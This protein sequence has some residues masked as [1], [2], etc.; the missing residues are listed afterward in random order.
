MVDHVTSATALVLP[1]AQIVA[2]LAERG[3]DTLVDGAHAP[4]MLDVD[5]DAT[6]A[7]YYTGT[8]HKWLFAP[9][10]SGFLHVRADLRDRVRPLAISHGA[11]STRKDR[12]PFRLEHDWTGTN[13]PS[14]LLTIPAAISFGASLVP[15]GWEALRRR[16]HELTLD[17][18][19]GVCGALGIDPPAPDD[20]IGSMAAVPL[21]G[22]EGSGSAPPIDV[23]ADPVHVSLQRHGIQAAVSPWPARPDGRPWR[24][25]LRFSV[26]PYVARQDIDR[27]ARALPEAVDHARVG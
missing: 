23:Y 13:D 25:L 4:G 16:D 19:D 3:I 18:R 17:G 27:L 8:C 11:N 24:R 7:A 10:G 9:K 2:A 14:A 15:G 20:M 21:P 22:L 26:A 5:I 12:S 6:G 1:V